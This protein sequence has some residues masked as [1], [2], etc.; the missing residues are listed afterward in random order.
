MLYDRY[1]VISTFK[2]CSIRRIQAILFFVYLSF[3]LPLIL[4]YMYFAQVMKIKS[5]IYCKKQKYF[6]KLSW[7]R[8]LCFL[9]YDTS[10]VF[11]LCGCSLLLF[12]ATNLLYCP[13]IL[14]KSNQ[15]LS[16]STFWKK[17]NFNAIYRKPA[18]Q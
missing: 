7:N 14:N 1:C 15:L 11:S 9:S 6:K 13:I 10:L 12:P 18:S 3:T 4:L 16:N 5:Y 2:S 17:Q 8:L